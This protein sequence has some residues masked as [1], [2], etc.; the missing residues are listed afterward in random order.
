VIGAEGRT[1]CGRTVGRDGY[2]DGS[3]RWCFSKGRRSCSCDGQCGPSNGCQCRQCYEDS[4]QNSSVS[5]TDTDGDV[6]EFRLNDEGSLDLFVNRKPQLT[7][8]ISLEADDLL[9]S[10]EGSPAGPWTSG[11][12]TTVPDDKPELVEKIMTMYRNCQLVGELPK[13][14]NGQIKHSAFGGDIDLELHWETPTTGYW[15]A[16]GSREDIQIKREGLNI[17]FSDGQTSAVCTIDEDRVL[18][19]IAKQ[20][21]YSEDGTVNLKPEGPQSY[22]EDGFMVYLKM[23][24]FNGE[25]DYQMKTNDMAACKKVCQ[26]RGYGGFTVWGDQVS[27]KAFSP[28]ELRD[29][30]HRDAGDNMLY[31]NLRLDEDFQ[32]DH[33]NYQHKDGKSF[34][35]RWEEEGEILSLHCDGSVV[36]SNVTDLE[37]HG[38][39]LC[40]H[41]GECTIYPGGDPNPRQLRMLGKIE[42]LFIR[43]AAGRMQCPSGH[44]MQFMGVAASGWSCDG[45]HRPGGCQ[46]GLRKGQSVREA[47]RY[48]CRLCDYDLCDGCVKSDR[49]KK[50]KEEK[51]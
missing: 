36:D 43:S 37:K 46:G 33:V 47:P 44:E 18:D 9:L 8:I 41:G 26:E 48:R 42:S 11:G 16:M 23:D 27:F 39:A 34:E 45:T 50:N 20:R 1:Y 19:G 2:Y 51:K 15:I 17:T 10:I 4:F 12:S 7:N 35:L 29:D 3:R 32:V 40:T 21:G 5:Y 24:S 49:A 30:M 25:D 6:I 14:W 31:I 13:C 38:L 28:Q 22:E